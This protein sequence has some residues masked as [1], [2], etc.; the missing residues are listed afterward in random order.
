MLAS[1]NFV[2]GMILHSVLNKTT[3]HVH[4]IAEIGI[5][6]DGNLHTA[7]ELIDAAK[8]AGVDAVKFQKRHLESIYT[9]ADIADPN[10]QERNIEYLLK[11]L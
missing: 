4:I 2:P 1:K 9:D 6:H 11:E 3:D 10:S 7:L 8:S 5:N